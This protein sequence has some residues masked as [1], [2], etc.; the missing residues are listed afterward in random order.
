MAK[1]KCKGT[2]LQL[3]I[4]S[5]F[6]AVSQLISVTPPSKGTLEY[7]STTLDTTTY[8]ESELTG[9]AEAGDLAAEYFYDPELAV[10]AAIEAAIDTP[11]ETNWKVI[12]VNSGASEIAFTCTRLEQSIAVAMN[13][14]LKASLVGKVDGK[15][16]LT[17]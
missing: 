4:A 1:V 13:D 11:A 16:T 15:P 8:K 14:G 12:F 17:V 10:Q 3:D 6:T 2:A 7:D 5:V 9:Y